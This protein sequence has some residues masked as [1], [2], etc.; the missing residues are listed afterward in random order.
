MHPHH[1]FGT[2]DGIPF[3]YALSA[4]MTALASVFGALLKIVRTDSRRKDQQ[5]EKK[6]IQLSDLTAQFIEN[7]GKMVAALTEQSLVM[8]QT[9]MMLH[10]AQE[11]LKRRDP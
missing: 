4:L 1:L 10:D 11:L 5:L 6:D 2:T 8:S 3:Q 9:Q 7:H